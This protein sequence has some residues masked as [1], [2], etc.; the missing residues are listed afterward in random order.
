MFIWA[1]YIITSASDG[2]GYPS[3]LKTNKIYTYGKIVALT[4]VR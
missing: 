3:G 1:F 4:D 2:S